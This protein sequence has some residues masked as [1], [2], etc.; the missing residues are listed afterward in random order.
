MPTYVYECRSCSG[1]F[2]VKQQ[3]TDPPL[4]TCESCSGELRKV[5]FP[6]RVIFKGSGWYI[7]DCKKNGGSKEPEAKETETKETETKESS[8][9]KPETAVSSPEA[10]KE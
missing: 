10:K 8:T 7:T 9:A 2:E 6:S 4:T 5:F 1:R 3:V